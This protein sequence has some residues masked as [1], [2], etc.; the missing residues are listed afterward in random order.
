MK[1]VNKNI[2]FIEIC[3]N[4][5]NKQF[6]SINHRVVFDYEIAKNNNKLSSA[7]LTLLNEND[8]PLIETETTL[9]ST[10]D[11]II[12]FF[13]SF[14]TQINATS[15]GDNEIKNETVF[16]A[17]ETD[18]W[19]SHASH[20]F[21]G[22]FSSKIKALLEVQIQLTEI[23]YEDSGFY[24]PVKSLINKDA[25]FDAIDIEKTKINNFK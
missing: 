3:A 4:A 14:I 6:A 17:F 20:S 13:V 11:L 1:N 12:D 23:V 21:L 24:K 5:L 18:V 19:N 2:E 9:L 7:I 25:S 22:V 15:I 16:V 8:L 10:T